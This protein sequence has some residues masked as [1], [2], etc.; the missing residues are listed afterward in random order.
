MSFNFN[1]TID[2]FNKA[3]TVPNPQKWFDAINANLPLYQINT[4][5]RVAAWIAQTGHESLGYAWIS[6]NLNYTA[7]QLQE[8]FPYYF[9]DSDIANNY[10]HQPEKI[11]NKVYANRMGN[12]AESS[13]DGWKYRG[14]GLIQL[15]GRSNYSKCSAS[16]YGDANILLNDP[17]ILISSDGAV[18]SACYFWNS[19]SLNSLADQSDMNQITQIING[20]TNGSAD[21]IA[22]YNRALAAL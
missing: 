11:A 6:E 20:G 17:D 10:A 9:P 19:H 16:L 21:R 14:R 1:F 8:V 15:T 22:R 3:I 5:L 7:I 12:G 18:R 2:N 4:K 13:G